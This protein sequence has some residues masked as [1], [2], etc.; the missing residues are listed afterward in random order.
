MRCGEFGDFDLLNKYLG[1]FGNLPQEVG[2]GVRRT[3]REQMPAANV[4]ENSRPLKHRRSEPLEKSEHP[5]AT[6]DNTGIVTQVTLT[7][8]SP[9]PFYRAQNS[10][11][12]A[13]TA[14]L[15]LKSS[16]PMKVLAMDHS[17]QRLM[18]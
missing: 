12:N 4:T 3:S 5:T 13:A 10:L 9:E 16:R 14:I 1:H 8:A 18:I 7:T 15:T 2:A 11:G 6:P 17:K